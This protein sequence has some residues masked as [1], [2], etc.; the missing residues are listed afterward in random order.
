MGVLDVPESEHPAL[1]PGQV[2]EVSRGGQEDKVDAQSVHAFLE[3]FSTLAIGHD[4]YLTFRLLVFPSRCWS[5]GLLVI[6]LLAN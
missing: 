1:E 3:L 5:F 6:R 4:N 2:L